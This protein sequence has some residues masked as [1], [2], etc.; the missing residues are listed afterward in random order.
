LT[1][2]VRAYF[3]PR[4]TYTAGRFAV[5]RTGMQLTLDMI[6]QWQNGRKEIVW[7]EEI[8]TSSAIFGKAVQ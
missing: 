7:P 8:H 5:D 6:I 3:K 4:L 2:D 1:D